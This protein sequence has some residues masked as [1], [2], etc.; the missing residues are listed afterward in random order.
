[1]QPTAGFS[2]ETTRKVICEDGAALKLGDYAAELGAR[3]VFLVTDK[4][5]VQAGLIDPA[6]AAMKAAGVEVEVFTDV[7]PDPPETAVEARSEEHT[8]ELQSH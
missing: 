1:M 8:S 6:V 3:R 5:L 2:F 4:G 7:L